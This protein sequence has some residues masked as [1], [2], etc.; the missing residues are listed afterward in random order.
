MLSARQKKTVDDILAPL[1]C[2]PDVQRMKCF[3]QHGTVTTFD[4]ALAVT[5]ASFEYAVRRGWRVDV[6]AL[7]RGAFLH[8]FYLYDWHIPGD[9]THRWHGF[10]HPRRAMEN[11]ASR[12]CLT[13]KEK[14][15]IFCHMW[16][17]TPLRFPRSRE[18]WI[19]ALCD[20]KVSTAETLRRS[21]AVVSD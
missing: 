9:G 21:A 7:V 12:F 2:D 17:L 3:I 4:H 16:P 8:D 14:M 10:H 18:G 11:A 1:L 20:K 15:I 13:R 5:Y 6:P 19:V